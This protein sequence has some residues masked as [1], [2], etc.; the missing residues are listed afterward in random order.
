MRKCRPRD[1]RGVFA[2]SA[3]VAIAAACGSADACTHAGQS[4]APATRTVH[5][6]TV[7]V[8]NR[9][10]ERPDTA[11]LREVFRIGQRE[12]PPEYTFES[13]N[14]FAVDRSGDIY[15]AEGRGPVR[16][17]DARGR[18][19]ALVARRGGGP[20]EVGYVTGM[21]VDADGRLLVRDNLNGR[22]NVYGVDGRPT[23][24][25]PLPPGRPA[26]GRDAIVSTA[27]GLHI[28]INPL[29][30]ESTGELTFPRPAYARLDSAGEPV[31][32]LLIPMRFT[33]ACPALS[34]GWFRSGW[35]EDLRA[36][37][38]PKVR[39]ALAPSGNLIVGCSVDYSFDIVQ[40]D[41]TVL[42]I[43]RDWIP[44][45]A[46]AEERES[47]QDA[48]SIERNASRFFQRWAWRGP[49]LPDTRPA[50]QRFIVAEDGTIWVWP[51]QARHA[52][53]MPAALRQRGYPARVWV[54]SRTGA[55]DVFEEDGR[56]LG[57][58]ALPPS[59]PYTADP[60]TVDPFMRGDTV[61]AVVVDSLDLEYLARFQVEWHPRAWR[62]SPR[63]AAP[64]AHRTGRDRHRPAPGSPSG[65]RPVPR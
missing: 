59:V 57:T 39:W 26:Y 30:P 37:Y 63:G 15:I 46:S 2:L 23:D 48:M 43:S 54:D 62:P 25:W 60:G 65:S 61:W 3:S 4:A 14:A 29:L 38:I 19:L 11:R 35:S 34:E 17:Y 58:V 28:G 16:Q 51:T 47:F 7:L 1:L 45:Q 8:H 55:F 31:D 24:H 18:F 13:I 21:V 20:G 49:A 5:A 52:E 22:V 36:P 44:V 42:R 10:P 27:L 56:W 40:R 41:D 33:E 53:S 9:A 32:T 12:G 64:A 50:Y 6:D